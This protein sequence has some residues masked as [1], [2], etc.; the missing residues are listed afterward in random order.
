[1]FLPYHQL[2]KL[3]KF[4]TLHEVLSWFGIWIYDPQLNLFLTALSDNLLENKTYWFHCKLTYIW[5]QCWQSFGKQYWIN[6]I[7][8]MSFTYRDE[9]TWLNLHGC[10]P[11]HKLW[12]KKKNRYLKRSSTWTCKLVIFWA[13][14]CYTFIQKKLR[15]WNN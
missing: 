4:I 5:G 3:Q 14:R 11:F 2:L 6:N 13:T 10:K 9:S 12:N 1:M 15:I 7:L 8:V